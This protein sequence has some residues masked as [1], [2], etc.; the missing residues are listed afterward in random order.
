[1]GTKIVWNPSD[2]FWDIFYVTQ[3]VKQLTDVSSDDGC[4]KKKSEAEDHWT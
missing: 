3:V 2:G 4:L 1:M